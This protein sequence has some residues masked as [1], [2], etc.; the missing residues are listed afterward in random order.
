[1][2]SASWCQ[3]FPDQE[4]LAR[5][6]LVAAMHCNGYTGL[7]LGNS[8]FHN[9]HL[10]TPMILASSFQEGVVRVRHQ[11]QV[12]QFGTGCMTFEKGN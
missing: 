7:C 8:R 6:Q 11:H 2:Q 4:L 9:F 3:A 12:A 1:M 5:V 10:D